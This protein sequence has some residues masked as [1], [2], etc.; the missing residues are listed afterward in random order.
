MKS[1]DNI[2][3]VYDL[4]VV[5]CRHVYSCRCLDLVVDIDVVLGIFNGLASSP[6]N[7]LGHGINVASRYLLWDVSTR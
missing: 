4:L 2:T 5:W 3:N 1:D 7:N 6:F